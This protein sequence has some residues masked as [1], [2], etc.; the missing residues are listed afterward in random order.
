MFITV[1][2]LTK[3]KNLSPKKNFETTRSFITDSVNDK[4]IFVHLAANY[5]M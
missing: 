5:H 2:I 1:N 4:N 3:R